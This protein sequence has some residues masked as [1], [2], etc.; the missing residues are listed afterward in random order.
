MDKVLKF[1]DKY[2]DKIPIHIRD[3]IQKGFIALTALAMLLAIVYGINRGMRE[4]LPSGVKLFE[5][6]RDLFYTDELKNENKNRLKL[7]EDVELN[8]FIQEKSDERLYPTLRRLGKDTSNHMIGESGD[9]IQKENRLSEKDKNL[10]MEDDPVYKNMEP[11]SDFLEKKEKSDFSGPFEND[12]LIKDSPL[13]DSTESKTTQG[14]YGQNKK[15]L[16]LIE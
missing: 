11:Q 16:D 10:F 14:E 2:I 6:S 7:I 15:S 5:K 1:I 12:F 3:I 13:K 4:S 9:M 8:L